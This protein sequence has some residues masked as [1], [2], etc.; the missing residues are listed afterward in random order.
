MSN[1]KKNDM[2]LIIAFMVFAPL[3]GL[4]QN[5]DDCN[6]EYRIISRNGCYSSIKQV[7]KNE[8]EL[9]KS[10]CN[11]PNYS[12]PSYTPTY[13]PNYKPNN[14]SRPTY[15]SRPNNNSRP[16]YS[17]SRSKPSNNNISRG[18]GSTTNKRGN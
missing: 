11:E 10:Y 16:S 3:F 5:C 15:N 1:F 18:N 7:E 8:I 12:K 2:R 13:K 9:Y 14:N 17:P 6:I 4:C